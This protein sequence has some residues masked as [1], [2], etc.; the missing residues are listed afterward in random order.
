MRRAGGI[1]A[2]VLLASA[3]VSGRVLRCAAASRRQ[4]DRAHPTAWL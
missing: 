2:L 4:T 3:M 1:F